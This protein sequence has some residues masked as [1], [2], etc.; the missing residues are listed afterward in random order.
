MPMSDNN[1]MESAQ[2]SLCHVCQKISFDRFVQE[3]TI[4]L[5]IFKELRTESSHCVL[6]RLIFQTM[7]NCIIDCSV[8]EVEVEN[9]LAAVG[10][11]EI[12]LRLSS[13]DEKNGRLSIVV[14]PPSIMIDGWLPFLE[15]G[16]SLRL[17]RPL[18][19]LVPLFHKTLSGAPSRDTNIYMCP[20]PAMLLAN[21]EDP[22]RLESCSPVVDLHLCPSF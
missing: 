17:F 19:E 7:K 6:C 14:G 18:G 10:P 22:L 3:R 8:L 2:S 11:S 21:L 12:S 5:R 1:V 9:Y 15:S 20:S 16:N 4:K 13:S